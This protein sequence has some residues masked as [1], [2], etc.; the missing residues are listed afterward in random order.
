MQPF[1]LPDFYMPY[2]ARLNPH[3]EG[4]RAHSKAWSYE[5]G[6]LEVSADPKH[7]PIWDEQDFDNHDYALLCAYTHPEC[8]AA[9]LDLVTDWYVWVFYFDDHFL[10]LYKRTRD[11]VGAKAYLD[12]IPLFMPLGSGAAAPSATNP[13]ERALADLW[14]RTVPGTSEDWRRRFLENTKHLLLESMWELANIEGNRVA[15]PVE[16]I[17]MRRKVGG[18][19]WSAGLVEHAVGAEV[20]AAIARTRPMKVLSDTFSD[21]VHL[22]ND[23]FSYQREVQDEGENA[24][25]ILVLERFLKVDTQRAA[26]LTNELLTSRLQQFENT[27]LVEVPQLCVDHGLSPGQCRDV[28]TYIRG[29]QDWQ[30]GGHEWHMRSSRYMNS[31]AHRSPVA[32]ALGPPSGPGTAAAKLRLSPGALGLQRIRNH[33]SQPLRPVGRS[34]LP[35]FYLPYPLRLSPHHGAVLRSTVAWARRMGMLEVIPGYFGSGIWTERQLLGFDFPLCG[36]GIHPDASFHELDLTGGWLTWGTYGD[37]FFPLVYNTSRDLAGA[38][39]HI[40]RLSLFMPLDCAATPPP[41]NPVEAGLADLWHRTAAPM[42]MVARTT[43]R[44][45]LET[46]LHSWLWELTNHLQHRVPDPID[47]VEMRRATFG[48][49][50]TMGLSKLSL[51]DLVP[52]EVFQTRTMRALDSTI[53]DYGGWTNDVFSYR[54]EIEFEGELHNLVLVVENFL[55]CSPREAEQVVVELMTARLLQFEHVVAT[56]LE[57]MFAD[58]KLD[59]AAREAVLGYIEKQR[60]YVSGVMNWHVK[61]SRYFDH[62]LEAGPVGKALGPLKGRGHAAAQLAALLTKPAAPAPAAAPAA[63]KFTLPTSHTVPLKL[64][65]R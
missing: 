51:G 32:G 33:T 36:A 10:E 34:P 63:A 5:M 11:S 7:P 31:E 8:D 52:A 50:L 57:G 53:A 64:G 9:E 47:Y 60:L 37:D 3:L 56:E 20:P 65:Q 58:F 18:A 21:G 30:S 22:R 1:Q 43:L 61:T 6:F 48:A 44:T 13:I 23:I 62:E 35:Q 29:L 49:D 55:E 15:N 26:D 38:K 45:S 14:A 28:A 25:C 40:Q 54:K 41:T 39:V 16:Y 12:R 24:N 59:R 2:P 17:E 46:M 19:P 42:S 27:A 4:A